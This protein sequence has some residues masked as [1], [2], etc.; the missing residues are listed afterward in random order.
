MSDPKLPPAPAPT[1]AAG[2]RGTVQPGTPPAPPRSTGAPPPPVPKTT[3]GRLEF[4]A[5]ALKLRD[6]QLRAKVVY[7]D[8]TL[9]TNA[10]LDAITAQV[11]KELQEMQSAGLAAHGS[12]DA[13]QVEIEL[14]KSLRDHLEK[15]LS[16]RREHFLRHKIEQIQRRITNLYFSSEIYA[17]TDD[18]NARG[19]FQ[20]ADEALHHV[21]RRHEANIVKDLE[22]LSYRDSRVL[23][24]SLDRFRI[25]QRQLVSQVLSRS[26]PDLERL[27]VIYRDVLL[28]FL[29]E[30]FRAQLGEFAWE[31]VKESRVAHGNDL[32]YKIREKAF[33]D[34]RLVF[35]RKFLDHLLATIQQPLT[36]RV[37]SSELRE[38]TLRFASEPRIYAEIC[39]VCCNAIYEYLHGEGFLDLP[40]D[41]QTHIARQ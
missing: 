34:F 41:W 38:E 12:L 26:M 1:T 21:L 3:K 37:A 20:Y 30:E 39:G 33:G 36:E 24:D 4:A 9:K 32:T 40:V 6:E 27:L 22:S 28:R 7:V 35:E 14:I 10:E 23:A 16:A 18:P 8:P 11:I 15:M 2:P 31:V 17:S 19:T 29:V 25:F 5:S 13:Q